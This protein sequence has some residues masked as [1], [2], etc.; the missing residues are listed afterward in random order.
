[1]L[2]MEAIKAREGGGGAEVVTVGEDLNSGV[3]PGFFTG[4]IQGQIYNPVK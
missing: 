3:S 2:A 4:L 1:M